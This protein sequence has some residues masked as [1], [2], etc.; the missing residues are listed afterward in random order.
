MR[1]H[2]VRGDDLRDA[3]RRAR[4]VHGAGAV[5]LS[6]EPAQGGGVTIAVRDDRRATP[7]GTG[8]VRRR[9]D[10]TSCSRAFVERVCRVVESRGARGAFA[11]DAAAQAIGT[12]FPV[13][14]SPKRT[15]GPRALAFVGPTG[16]GKTTTIAKLGLR[17]VRAGRRVALA[18]LDTY[19]VGAVDQLRTYAELLEVPLHVAKNGNQLAKVL[20]REARPAGAADVVLVDTTGRSPGDGDNLERLGDDL[21]RAG[22]AAPL[23]SLLVLPAPLANAELDDYARAFRETRPSALVLTKLDETT[24]VGAALERT[25]RLRL[26]YAFLCDGQDVTK[27]LFRAHPERFADLVLRGRIA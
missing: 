19:R 3:L 1:I 6:H 25:L 11:I 23:Q 12:L 15:S 27:H 18:T 5:V 4:D 13:A 26:A 2:R 16:A 21:A 22:L 8:E 14:P 20:A 17:L 10:A 24:R 9:M 7:V